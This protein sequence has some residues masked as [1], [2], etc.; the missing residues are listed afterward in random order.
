MRKVKV[1]ILGVGAIGS[2]MASQLFANQNID[3]HYFNR[4]PKKEIRLQS[5]IRFFDFKINT[6]TE[7]SEKIEMD[8]LI[9]CLKEYHFKEAGNWFEKLIFPKTKIAVVR[10]G[11]NLKEPLLPY[12]HESQILEGMIDCPT[13]LDSDGNFHQLKNGIITLPAGHLADQFQVLFQNQNISIRQ[14]DN[15]KSENWKKLIESAALGAI[16]C[17][18]GET[19]WIFE[20]KF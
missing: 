3:L 15:F 14:V 12:A 1:G 19:C 5:P 6:Q 20:D 2:V 17:L 7:L 10:N 16:T 11:I 13:Q 9:I 18:A 4:S 8:W